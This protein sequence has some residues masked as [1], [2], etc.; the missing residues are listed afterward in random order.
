METTTEDDAVA[1]SEASVMI[2]LV[3][4]VLLAICCAIILLES[5]ST[6]SSRGLG[7]GALRAES[8][9]KNLVLFSA[10]MAILF[11][12]FSAVQFLG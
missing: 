3:I 5:Y 12:F 11:V 6:D 9:K 1:V 8:I 2:F 4:G 10:P 7:A